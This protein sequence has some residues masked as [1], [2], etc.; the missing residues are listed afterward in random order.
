[1][2]HLYMDLTTGDGVRVY[3]TAHMTLKVESTE[4]LSGGYCNFVWRAKLKT[5]Y[6]G[7]NSV[8]VKYAAPFTSWD[9]TI[10]LGV[11]RLVS[12]VHSYTNPNADQA[13][14]PLPRLLNVCRSK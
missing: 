13:R 7:Q 2:A 4:R 1:M 9:Q 5:P 10:E 8:I 3:L 11:E 12:N 14:E 6:E